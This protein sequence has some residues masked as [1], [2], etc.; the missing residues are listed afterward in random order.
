MKLYNR[1]H[2]LKGISL[3]KLWEILKDRET[4]SAAPRG[5]KESDTSEKFNN[6]NIIGIVNIVDDRLMVQ[7]DIYN[8]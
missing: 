7:E 1:S 3:N 4:W 6:N 8:Y 2:Q 5:H